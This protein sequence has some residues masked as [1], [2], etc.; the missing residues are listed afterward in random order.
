MRH[1]L[2]SITAA[3]VLTFA[4]VAGAEDAE[5][6]TGDNLILDYK[7]G[8]VAREMSINYVLGI[9]D[10]LI[11]IQH[12]CPPEETMTMGEAAETVI[13]TIEA[14]RQLREAEIP[15]TAIAA[16]RRTYPCDG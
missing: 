14:D 4:S 12:I 13:H 1:L 3:M 10:T 16:A 15:A 9:L 11:L 5:P 6:L 7:A 8:P 2:A